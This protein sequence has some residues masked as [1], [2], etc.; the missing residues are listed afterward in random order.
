MK[1]S[2]LI[3]GFLVAFAFHML[4]ISVIR[5]AVISYDNVRSATMQG[6][7]W[8]VIHYG[9]IMGIA[10]FSWRA[11]KG[12]SEESNQVP[13]Q[14]IDQVDVNVIDVIQT[15]NRSQAQSTPTMHNETEVPAETDDIYDAIGKEIEE[16]KLDRATWTKAF[17]DADGDDAKAK[18]AYIR[19]RFVKL[20][21]SSKKI[22]EPD[23]VPKKN[24][25]PLEVKFNLMGPV[26]PLCESKVKVDES[27]C[28]ACGTRFLSEKNKVEVTESK[29]KASAETVNATVTKVDL[30]CPLCER[31]V[32]ADASECWGCGTRFAYGFKPKQSS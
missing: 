22:A 6:A 21:D 2:T 9:V 17:A 13:V 10:W 4:W 14:S 8:G 26:C 28:W 32:K 3:G 5:D 1:W 15:T 11:A 12:T 20:S 19:L 16:G 31:W 24:V 29:L 18:A 23:V 27:E 7:F 25:E 30:K